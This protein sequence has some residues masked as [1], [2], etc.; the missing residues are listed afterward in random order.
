MKKYQKKNMIDSDAQLYSTDSE[1]SS[2][3]KFDL[4]TNLVGPPA[5]GTTK[6]SAPQQETKV[7]NQRKRQNNTSEE[8]T[9]DSCKT[10]SHDRSSEKPTETR[11]EFV[12]N[13]L[14]GSKLK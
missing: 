14:E 4:I 3:D 8:E 9:P 13:I 1:T 12:R 10:K 11:I 6:R 7:T 2:S 5:S